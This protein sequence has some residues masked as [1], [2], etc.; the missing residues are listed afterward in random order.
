MKHLQT[1]V[2]QIEMFSINFPFAALELRYPMQ[3]ES[4]YEN[5]ANLTGINFARL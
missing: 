5:F 2:K 1:N 3:K 4:M